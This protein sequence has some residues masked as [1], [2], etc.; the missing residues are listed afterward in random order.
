MSLK[1]E[2][3]VRRFTLIQIQ[4]NVESMY[5]S[6]PITEGIYWVKKL[7]SGHVRSCKSFTFSLNTALDG[8]RLHILFSPIPNKNG[9]RNRIPIT[10]PS[11]FTPNSA[12]LTELFINE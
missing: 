5:L 10:L 2:V 8:S 9:I 4:I 6:I 3:F 12:G 11:P 7:R 1:S